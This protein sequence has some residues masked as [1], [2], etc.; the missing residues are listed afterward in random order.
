MI[1]FMVFLLY[2]NLWNE[3]SPPKIAL[4]LPVMIG[5][6]PRFIVWWGWAWTMHI[7]QNQPQ[8]WFAARRF[9]HPTT[10]IRIHDNPSFLID[11]CFEKYYTRFIEVTPSCAYF[12]EYPVLSSKHTRICPRVFFYIPSKK[13]INTNGFWTDRQGR[14]GKKIR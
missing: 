2:S 11:S 7:V 14:K 9:V 12:M 6:I 4:F 10:S 1:S 5:L 8:V 13:E 3:I